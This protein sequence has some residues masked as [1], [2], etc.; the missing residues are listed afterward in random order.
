[1]KQKKLLIF[2]I[3]V[4]PILLSACGGAG[5]ASSTAKTEMVNGITIPTAPDPNINA[6]T[7]EGVDSNNNGVRDDVERKIATALKDPANFEKMAAYA[8]AE[9]KLITAP[10]PATRADALKMLSESYC[11]MGLSGT[12]EPNILNNDVMADTQSRKDKIDKFNFV[13]GG[14]FGGE[15][16]CN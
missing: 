4:L 3:L 2:G 8:K 5:N 10:T 16:S 15:I 12:I 11:A 6:A 13:V 9:E 1:M 7:L 14:Y